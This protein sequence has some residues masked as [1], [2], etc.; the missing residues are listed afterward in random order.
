MPSIIF[1]ISNKEPKSLFLR[2]FVYC[3]RALSTS[4]NLFLFFFFVSPGI[5]LCVVCMQGQHSTTEQYLYPFRSSS[6]EFQLRYGYRWDL[7]SLVLS[8]KDTVFTQLKGN[9][10]PAHCLGEWP[11]VGA[12][13]IIH[14]GAFVKS[15]C[16]LFSNLSNALLAY[17]WGQSC[18]HSYK[19]NQP[20]H[21]V[22]TVKAHHQP[23]PT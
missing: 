16:V 11:A 2:S 15:L 1:S 5:K 12:R 23:N 19:Q 3:L 14:Q 6:Q 9:F 8:Q 7:P 22:I 4:Q 18:N 17:I 21:F 13:G 10:L 20:I